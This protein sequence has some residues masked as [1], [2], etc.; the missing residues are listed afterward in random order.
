MTDKKQAAEIGLGDG[1]AIALES[2]GIT[3]DRVQVVASKIGVSDC[4]CGRRRSAL[5]ELGAKFLGLP[6]GSTAEKPID[7]Q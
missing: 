5:N 1:V 2:I 3:K 6:P 7:S 4:G